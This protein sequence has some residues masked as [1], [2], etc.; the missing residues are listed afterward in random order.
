MFMRQTDNE[1]F[2][3][4]LNCAEKNLAEIYLFRQFLRSK[5]NMRKLLGKS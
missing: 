1:P 2:G 3:Q 5:L 4:Q